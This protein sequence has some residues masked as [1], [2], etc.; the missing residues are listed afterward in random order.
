M[1]KST[2]MTISTRP[3]WSLPLALDPASREPLFVQI[4]RAITDDVRRGRIAPGAR[5]P[6]SR[7]LAATLSVH[8]NT[9]LAA[10]DELLSEGWIEAS[11][12]RGTFV[13]ASLP[14]A[15]PRRFSE[16]LVQRRRVPAR[17]GF[18][19]GPAPEPDDAAVVPPGTLVMSGGIPDVRL[20]PVA[21]LG[22]A[23][24]R[25][26]R[27]HAGA[28]LGY[29]GPQGHP[30]LRAALAEMLSATRGL[31]TGPDDLVVTRGTQMALDLVARALL[32]PGDVVA[33]EGPGYRPAWEAFRQHGARLVPLPVDG[34]GVDP[35]AL[36]A[37]ARRERVRA[38]YVTPHH[39]YPTTVTLS[40]GRRLALLDLARRA[41]I[42]VVEDDFDHELHF[43]GR[44]VLPLASVDRAG[45]VVYVGT[46]AKILAPGLRLGYVAGPRQLLHGIAAH[47]T[48]VDRQGD[49][50]VE[51][52]VA[53]LLEDGE[54][55]RHARRARRIYERR[56]A[57]L[58]EAL[59]RSLGGILSFEVPA[60]GMAL[61]ARVDEHVDV[62]AWCRRAL[63]QGVAFH[64][65]RRFAFD[66]RPSPHARFGFTALTEPELAEGVRRL[67]R[68]LPARRAAA[69][70]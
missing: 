59:R 12:A 66:G 69:R 39:Q 38:V 40:P 36:E 52:A 29:A 1:E 24:R 46:L 4:A 70:R 22:R 5:L 7:T 53:E 18:D 42:A 37:L 28:A 27:A 10:Y 21:E 61:W 58:V 32:S 20:V 15:A 2:R 67:V 14:D 55:Q 65:G 43:E 31:A 63:A 49:Q 8:R 16:Q 34:D 23:Y 17:A 19:L 35:S 56:R 50:A 62:D 41:R 60:G 47:R 30:R 25:A 57:F 13:S 64:A 11:A 45:V 54:V 9:V 68:S 6:G 3:A 44:P 48:L 26:I 33:V 51:C